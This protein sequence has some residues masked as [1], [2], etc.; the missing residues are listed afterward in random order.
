MRWGRCSDE[1]TG[2]ARS[3]FVGHHAQRILA[4]ESRL[5]KRERLSV[6]WDN[7][8]VNTDLMTRSHEISEAMAKFDKSFDVKWFVTRAA[9]LRG[10]R[11]P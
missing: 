8:R 7:V 4:P 9:R 2:N 3:S 10:A 1:L 5:I 6:L 11:V